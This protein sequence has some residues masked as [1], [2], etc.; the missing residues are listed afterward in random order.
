MAI[1]RSQVCSYLLGLV[2]ALSVAVLVFCLKS[3]SLVWPSAASSTIISAIDA[4]NHTTPLLNLTH[5]PHILHQSWIN[6]TVP[7][8]YAAWRQSW[9]TNHK[10]WEFKLWTDDDNEAL[11]KQYAPWFLRRY[12]EFEEPVMRADSVRYLYM[13]RYGGVYA[14]LDFESLK[15]LDSL[16]DRGKVLLGTMGANS[17]PEHSIPNSFM[18]SIP[19]HPFWMFCFAKMLSAHLGIAIGS[20]V[21]ATTGPIMLKNALDEYRHTTQDSEDIAVLPQE[22]IFPIVWSDPATHH[23]DCSWGAANYSS[24][25]CHRHFEDAYAVTYWAHGWR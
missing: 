18:A 6:N 4:L 5:I 21:E 22:Y 15:P 1:G 25:A 19:G 20:Y 3:N 13:Y 8:Q 12:W 14:D 9:V 17:P 24:A 16:L 11:V 10:H 7:K 2:S 23:R